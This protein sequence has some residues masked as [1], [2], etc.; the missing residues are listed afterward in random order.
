MS[1]HKKRAKAMEALIAGTPDLHGQTGYPGIFHDLHELHAV[2]KVRMNDRRRLLEVFHAARAIDTTLRI[3]TKMKNCKL[4]GGKVPDS[5]GEYLAALNEHSLTP[6]KMGTLSKAL[7]D[8]Y[9]TNI[10]GQRNKYFHQAGLVPPNN[11]AV[12]QFVSEVEACVAV[13]LAL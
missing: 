4:S 6:T 9:Q 3:F 13:V 1:H 12:E 2:R 8:Q 7:R 11:Q 10:A 5:L